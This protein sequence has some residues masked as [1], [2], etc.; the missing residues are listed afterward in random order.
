M[1]LTSPH[2]AVQAPR[3]LLLPRSSPGW[4]LGG[5]EAQCRPLSLSLP[6]Q[7]SCV[8]PWPVHPKAV[9][10]SVPSR[11]LRS[12]QEKRFLSA[13]AVVRPTQPAGEEKPGPD[14]VISLILATQDPGISGGARHTPESGQRPGWCKAPGKQ[15]PRARA[16]LGLSS[17]CSA[18][19]WAPEDKLPA[20]TPKG[21]PEVA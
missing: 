20:R 2:K 7:P 15:G 10:R 9:C 11:G 4:S 16:K 18:P 14:R 1:G 3:V 13:A 12:P 17:M 21:R 6:P 5:R 8:E 19:R